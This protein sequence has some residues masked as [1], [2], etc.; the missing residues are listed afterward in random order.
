MN[1][2][3]HDS[4]HTTEAAL[5]HGPFLAETSIVS[6]GGQSASRSRHL[7]SWTDGKLFQYELSTLSYTCC[8]DISFMSC[9]KCGST[10]RHNSNRDCSLNNDK[11][12]ETMDRFSLELDIH[13]RYLKKRE[14]YKACQ[15]RR[16]KKSSGG[17]QNLSMISHHVTY[18]VTINSVIHQPWIFTYIQQMIYW[19]MT[20]LQF[21]IS[22]H[23]TSNINSSIKH[24]IRHQLS[25]ITLIVYYIINQQH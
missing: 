24:N 25:S 16:I 5:Y 18:F 10:T 21:H 11:S 14:N 19:Y 13:R 20:M 4:A 6:Y 12:Y 7:Y 15:Q 1:S 23:Q 2:I 9:F 17:E 3:Y 22:Q 8:F